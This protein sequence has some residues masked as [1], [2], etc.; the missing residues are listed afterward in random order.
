MYLSGRDIK[1]AIECG[2]LIVDPPPESFNAGY[3]ETS[4]DL[5]LDSIDNGASV[6]DT[7]AYAATGAQALRGRGI[8][9]PGMELRIGGP[10]F[11]YDAVS[12][13][14]ISPPDHE[15]GQPNPPLVFRRRHP[16]QIVVRRFGFI[17]WTT[18]EVIGTPVLD[19]LHPAAKQRHPE[20]ICFVAG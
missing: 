7:D 3:D 13:F 8:S 20:L 2:R 19:L 9:T 1:W 5:H 10:G 15:P 11:D 4:I 6:W 12:E 16:D 18:K 17:L 14:L